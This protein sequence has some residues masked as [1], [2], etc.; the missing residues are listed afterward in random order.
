MLS[1]ASAL[2]LMS[3]FAI[4]SAPVGLGKKPF[5]ANEKHL[6]TAWFSTHC[7]PLLKNLAV[8]DLSSL[9]VV[10]QVLSHGK[11]IDKPIETI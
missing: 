2:V 8:G 4:L 3:L 7:S 9:N 6:V 5:I 10:Y 1:L 11:S